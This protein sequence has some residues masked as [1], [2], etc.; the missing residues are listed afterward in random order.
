MKTIELNFSKHYEEI[1]KCQSYKN[2]SNEMSD[3]PE[4]KKNIAEIMKEQINFKGGKDE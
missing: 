3:W 4:W 1:K 2:I